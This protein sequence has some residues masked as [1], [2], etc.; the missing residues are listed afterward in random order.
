MTFRLYHAAIARNGYGSQ[1][2][3]Q[4]RLL[5][6]GGQETSPLTLLLSL[7][8]NYLLVLLTDDDDDDDNDIDE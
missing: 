8:P 2:Y 5:N 3:Y 7:S 6:I 1:R 4:S